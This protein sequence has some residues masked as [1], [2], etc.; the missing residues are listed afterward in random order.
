MP[1]RPPL[2]LL[3]PVLTGLCAG[4]LVLM[5]R[6]QARADE[7]R[8]HACAHDRPSAHWSHGYDAWLPLATL[9]LGV[10]AVVL[11]TVLLLGRRGPARAASA[12]ALPVALLLLVPAGLAADGYFRFP[13][14]DI[15]T[16]GTSP[17]GVG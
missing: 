11:A 1:P 6:L 12:F 10:A 9:A 3:P 5:G 14:A 8:E 16:V 15:S 4:G 13:G 7:A 2:G 17:C